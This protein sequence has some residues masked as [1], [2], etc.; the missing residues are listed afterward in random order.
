[1]CYSAQCWANWRKYR[2][3]FNSRISIADFAE[4]YGYK[5]RAAAA[6][7]KV[8]TPKGMDDAF[9]DP[10]TP[11]EAGIWAIIEE[12]NKSEAEAK[13]REFF[14]QRTR[15]VDAQRKLQAKVTKKAENDLRVSAKKMD[16]A[17]LKLE[18]LRRTEPA[19]RDSRIFPFWWAPV[20]VLEAGELVVKPMRYHCRLEGWH[21]GMEG[22]YGTYNA[23]RDS[24]AK[25]WKKQFGYQ[26]SVMVVNR[27]YE[28]VD[29]GGENVVLEFNPRP[30][31]DML[32]A[33]LWQRSI[34]FGD[35]L[36]AFYSF[37][38]ITDEPPEE[39]AAAGHDRCIVPIKRENLMAWLDPDPARLDD[40]Q[41]ILE[42]RDRP[43]YEHRLAA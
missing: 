10:Q 25:T 43:Y 22:K 27:F 23:R 15:H 29:R 5:R 7:V 28:N 19:D 39:V 17:R 37:A 11:E 34:G 42:D 8:R 9:R 40:L 14:E 21:A 12:L 13:Q 32:V 30:A 1:M 4:L 16:D 2:R 20:M 18:D 38:A 35:E 33:C 24:L 6:G 31:H 36:P 41:A 3:E 26:H